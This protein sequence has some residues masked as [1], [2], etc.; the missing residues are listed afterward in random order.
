MDSSGKRYQ[1]AAITTQAT[2]A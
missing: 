2:T 1:Q